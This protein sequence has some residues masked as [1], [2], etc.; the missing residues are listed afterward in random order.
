MW[1]SLAIATLP[2]P[3]GA[4]ALEM[5]SPDANALL[6]VAILCIASILCTAVWL[7]AVSSYTTT[8]HNRMV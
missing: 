8:H 3:P 1:I 2:T 4:T 6:P 7:L 5:P